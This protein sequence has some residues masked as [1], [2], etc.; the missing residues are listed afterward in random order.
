MTQDEDALLTAIME[1][2]AEQI[3]RYR[4]LLDM[5]ALRVSPPLF[6]VSD[7]RPLFRR[8]TKKQT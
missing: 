7:F 4:Y 5:M 6:S 2:R 1:T 3:E 8:D